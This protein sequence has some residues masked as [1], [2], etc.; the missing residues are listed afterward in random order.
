MK[1]NRAPLGQSS[2]GGRNRSMDQ[3]RK[4]KKNYSREKIRKRKV[5]KEDDHQVLYRTKSVNSSWGESY[6]PQNQKMKVVAVKFHP[7]QLGEN[8]KNWTFSRG[9]RV[10]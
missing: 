5:G 6:H 4:G 10:D 7:Q 9:L 1:R 2:K 3:W 8:M